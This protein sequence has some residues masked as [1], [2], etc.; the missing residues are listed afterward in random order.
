MGK[1]IPD[2]PYIKG[3]VRTSLIDYPGLIATVLYTACCNLRCPFCHNPELLFGGEDVD[4]I[5]LIEILNFSNL[6][7]G[8]VEG[9]V[10]SGGEPLLH[11]SIIDLLKLLRAQA[12]KIKLD[13]NGC[14]PD[15]LQEVLHLGLVDMVAMDIKASKNA[16]DK[17]TGIR[18]LLPDKVVQSLQILKSSNIPFE[19]RT[20]IIPDFHTKEMMRDIAEWIAPVDSYVLQQF[21]PEDTFAPDYRKL[22][23]LSEGELISMKQIAEQYIQNVSIRGLH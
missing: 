7:K 17:A 22:K 11:A 5:D 12:L 4:S 6:R 13:T 21:Q 18:H 2:F 3:W 8:M 1:S 9:I 19:L 23:P 15:R 20:T 10:V 14:F 16:Y